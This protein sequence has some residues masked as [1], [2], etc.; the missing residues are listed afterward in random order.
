MLSLSNLNKGFQLYIFILIV[1]IIPFSKHLLPYAMFLWVLSGVL[2]IRKRKFENFTSNKLFLFAPLLFYFLHIIGLI[3]TNNMHSGIF[4]LEIKLSIFFIPVIIVFIS[5]KVLQRKDIIL[6]VFVRANFIVSVICLII[7]LNNSIVRTEQG[8]LIFEFSHWP[9][10]TE[11]FSFVK[12]INYRYS[13]LSHAFLSI[14]QHPSYFALY[15]LF[16]I[17]ILLYF[18][19]S[20][21]QN[22]WFNYLLVV[23]F[24]GFIWLLGSRAAYISYFI[25]LVLFVS[26]LILKYKRYIVILSGFI[27]VL[28]AFFIILSN[29][30]LQK[31]LKESVSIVTNSMTLNENSD[32]RLWLWKSGMQIFKDNWL[33][34]VGTGDI[35]LSL[36]TIYKEYGLELADE[37]NYNTH[38]Q[39]LDVAI[40]LG[41]FGLAAFLLWIFGPIY[42]A[43]KKKHF[44]LFFFMLIV[45]INLFFE[46]M[47]NTISGVSFIAFFYSLLIAGVIKKGT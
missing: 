10:V 37:H 35:D 40:K 41:V 1:I 46:N 15:I 32:I 6:S 12:L 25:I 18:I 22:K 14:F 19:K 28:A 45:A 47:L 11:G 5:D 4:D 34:G 3:Y 33:F 39:Y 30:Q 44:L 8:G 26:Y 31:N 27:V 24:S 21:K 29:K 38:N 20:G 9:T 16:S 7:A 36:D 13:N 2:L 42:V 43:L 23:Y 17:V